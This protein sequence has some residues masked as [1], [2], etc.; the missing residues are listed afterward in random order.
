MK[1]V[2]IFTGPEKQCGIHYYA[3][4]VIGILQNSQQ[5]QY[6]LI[7]VG[8]EIEFRNA[9]QTQKPDLIVVNWH[10]WTMPW[11]TPNLLNEFS[12][13]KFLIIGHA[14]LSDNLPFEV[15]KFI[16]IDPDHKLQDNYV[17]G[18]RP[19]RFYDD[20]TYSS[21]LNRRLVIGTSGIG[22]S[23]K[24]LEHLTDLIRIQ[25][26]GEYI[27][28]FRVHFSVG[29]Y[30]DHNETKIREL[31]KNCQHR[32]GEAIQITLT[33]KSFDDYD[34]VKWLNQNDINIFLY[35][36]FNSIGVSAS[37]DKALA[38]RKPIG[39]NDSNFFR[40]IYSKDIDIGQN[41]LTDIVAKG[42]NPLEKFY[43]RWNQ[44]QLVIQYDTL[45]SQYV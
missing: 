25:Y 39:I 43:H 20:I 27:I 26:T 35:N 18:V 42:I 30:T 4:T 6:K 7:D 13:P 11:C 40:H 1:T 41:L 8:S 19:V 15:D 28:D 37:I 10:P 21:P 14:S 45:V 31:V 3:D 2:A 36:S 9:I 22:H 38:A 29:R 44:Q 32:A 16:S 34:L 5:Y 23:I 33:C 12:M 17:G 24:N